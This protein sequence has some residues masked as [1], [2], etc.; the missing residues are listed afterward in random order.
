MY[1][2]GLAHTMAGSLGEIPE[3]VVAAACDTTEEAKELAFEINAAR[4]RAQAG[5]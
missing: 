5:W 4:Y 3:S 1:F 2:D